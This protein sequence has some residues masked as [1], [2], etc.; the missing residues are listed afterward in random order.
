MLECIVLAGGLGTR[1]R[2]IVAE[3]PKP[4]APIRER[5]FLD[6]LF[7]QFAEAKSIGRVILAVGYKGDMI[8]EYYKQH[9]YPFPIDFSVEQE[10]LGTG[11]ALTQALRMTTGDHVMA[12]N[13]DSFLEIDFPAFFACHLKND[14]DITLACPEVEDVSRYGSLAVDTLTGKIFG[15][16]EK[17]KKKGRGMVNGGV[18]L[19]KK[20]IF[21][22]VPSGKSFSLEH[23]I[24][25]LL[26]QQ[27]MFAFRC[28]G[29]FIDIGTKTSFFEAQ[30]IL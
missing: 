11:G 21:R 6:I 15:F 16:T 27:R 10:P 18:Y 9:S 7:D 17:G 26:V 4:L 30:K 13:G 12:C 8:I 1:L 25:P 24:F 28:A 19:L 20:A 14:S 23:E 29:K 22:S 2:D 3:V 5:P